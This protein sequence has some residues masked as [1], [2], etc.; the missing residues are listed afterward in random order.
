MGGE[1]DDRMDMSLSKL[2]ELV[3]D[4][5]AWCAAAHGSHK[6]SDTTEWLKWTELIVHTEVWLWLYESG[7][8]LKRLSPWTHSVGRSSMIDWPCLPGHRVESDN[9]CSIFPLCLWHWFIPRIVVTSCSW[10]G[11]RWCYGQ[12]PNAKASTTTK[13]TI[14]M[15]SVL[16]YRKSI[17]IC[18]N[19]HCADEEKTHWTIFHE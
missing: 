17:F 10:S 18:K 6:E 12:A 4:R 2:Q 5:E 13:Q 19:A 7:W 8:V 11:W 16:V 14:Q 15:L 9:P 3:K 1:G